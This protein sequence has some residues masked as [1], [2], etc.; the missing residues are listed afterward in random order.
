MFVVVIGLGQVGR[1]VVRTLERKRH[2][3]V[4]VDA[5]LAA[6][7]YI[8][9][10]HD[11]QSVMGYGASQRVLMDAKA[12][13][14]DLVCAVTNNDEV[15]LIAAL[16]ARNLGAK[17]TIA[18]VEGRQWGASD[19]STGVEYGLLGVDVVFNPKLLIARE[20]SKI[21]QSHG[22]A[23]VI[24]LA[25][26]RV[27][28]VAVDLDESSKRTHQPLARIPFP[29]GMLIAAVVR[30]HDLFVPGGNDVLLPG[31]RIYLVGL[32]DKLIAAE[33]LFT[34]TKEAQSICIVGGGVIGESL[35]STLLQTGASVT[36]IERDKDRARRIKEEQPRATVIDGD[37]TDLALLKEYDIGT[38]DLFAAVTGEDE[39]N[40]M[41]ALLAKNHGAKRTATVVHRPDYVDIHQQ[42]GINSVL[43][44]RQ[45]A[46]DHVLRYVRHRDFKPVATLEGGQAQVIEIRALE[47][48]R[49]IGTPL[50]QMRVPRGAI[51]CAI[52]KGDQA[53]IPHGDTVIH[54]GDTVVALATERAFDRLEALF[55]Q[56]AF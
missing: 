9:E 27:E 13:Q 28:I 40:L 31:D 6:I 16:A 5:E 54:A 35:A 18:R 29:E 11:V 8:E 26:D 14:A 3:V 19:D 36:L 39:V 7:Q 21:A 41:A 33:D 50:Q 4:A 24:E 22:A 30:D 42:L 53:I 10:H 1:H 48:A 15:N 32:P 46:S 43:S 56:R 45:L 37:G 52:L 17:R 55:K 49:A 47:G 12:D 25:N 44:P 23:E 34:Y 2:D 51:L 20:L 38:F